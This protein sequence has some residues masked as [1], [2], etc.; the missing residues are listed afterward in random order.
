[1]G[2]GAQLALI[3]GSSTKVGGT[4][5]PPTSTAGGLRNWL[6]QDRGVT[7]WAHE[8]RRKLKSDMSVAALCSALR[9][10][11]FIQQVTTQSGANL[12]RMLAQ[13]NLSLPANSLTLVNALRTA[14]RSKDKLTQ[15]L[16]ILAPPSG[17][18]AA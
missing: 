3:F 10:A 15:E 18:D 11:E 14:A 7:T 2:S 1:M 16:C 12:D 9:Y 6:P 17:S 5:I 4:S 13:W 8:A